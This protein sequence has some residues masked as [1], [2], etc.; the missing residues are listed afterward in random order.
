MKKHK[1]IENQLFDTAGLYLWT[2][3]NAGLPEVLHVS[4]GFQ[5]SILFKDMLKN[6]YRPLFKKQLK[7]IVFRKLWYKPWHSR[8]GQL[9][10]HIEEFYCI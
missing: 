1:Q 2:M 5:N 9:K 6:K 4:F 8:F 10:Y 3:L 7:N